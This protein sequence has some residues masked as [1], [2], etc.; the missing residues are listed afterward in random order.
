MSEKSSAPV[1]GTVEKIMKSPL[2]SEPERAQ[3][4]MEGSDLL[5]SGDSHREH[6]GR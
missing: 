6:A 3:I 2:A 5:V 4:L 1:P